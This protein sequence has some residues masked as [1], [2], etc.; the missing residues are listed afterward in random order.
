MCLQDVT[1]RFLC[2][3]WQGRIAPRL[4]LGITNSNKQI[5]IDRID[6]TGDLR[7]TL[8]LAA[9]PDISSNPTDIVLVLDR[10]GSMAGILLD[11]LKVG[12]THL[13]ISSTSRRTA[14]RIATS[15]QGTGSVS[16]VLRIPPQRTRS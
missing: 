14:L 9:A 5:S 2:I 6:C 12:P 15:A 4:L 8:A 3:V 10:S 1:T 7:V 13:L 11:N 16:S